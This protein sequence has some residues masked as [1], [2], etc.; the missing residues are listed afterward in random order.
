MEDLPLDIIQMYMGRVGKLS[1]IY[2]LSISWHWSATS[3][4]RSN[5][6]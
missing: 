6:T 4:G 2:D 5:Q 3:L 1:A